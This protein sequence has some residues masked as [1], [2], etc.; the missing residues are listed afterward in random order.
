MAEPRRCRWR[1]GETN[2]PPSVVAA[3]VKLGFRGS[4]FGGD[5]STLCLEEVDG[6]GGS[7]AGQQGGAGGVVGP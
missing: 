7:T 4:A 5:S 1:Q 3:L 6:V 2:P